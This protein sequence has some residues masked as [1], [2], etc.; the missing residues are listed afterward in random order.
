MQVSCSSTQLHEEKE[1][2]DLEHQR[3]TASDDQSKCGASELV[4]SAL[5]RRSAAAGGLDGAGAR[6]LDDGDGARG[7]RVGCR[8]GS[9]VGNCCA[10]DGRGRGDGCAVG[11][12]VLG[13]GGGSEDGGDG[14]D[15]ELHGCGVVCGWL[16]GR[17]RVV[18][19]VLY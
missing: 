4:R 15:G 3:N 7:R 6:G 18:F 8:A 9:R 2:V 12:S 11:D 5:E 10:G 14:E 13:R 19:V 16:V 1:V 17:L